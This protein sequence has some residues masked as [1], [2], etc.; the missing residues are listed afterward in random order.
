MVS[1]LVGVCESSAECRNF[2]GAGIIPPPKSF[3]CWYKTLQ[4]PKPSQVRNQ[5]NMR[6]LFAPNIDAALAAHAAKLHKQYDEWVTFDLTVVAYCEHHY[7]S[8]ADLNTFVT[9][10]ESRDIFYALLPAFTDLL[11]FLDKY[12]STA[13]N[14]FGDLPQLNWYFSSFR[15]NGLLEY[16][17]LT[18][19]DTSLRRYLTARRVEQL[20]LIGNFDPGPCILTGNQ[21]IELTQTIAAEATATFA[22]HKYEETLTRFG[23]ISIAISVRRIL[24]TWYRK[25]RHSLDLTLNY[26]TN[27]RRKKGSGTLIFEPVYEARFLPLAH[28]KVYF[29]PN[30]PT[31]MPWGLPKQKPDR[32]RRPANLPITPTLPLPFSKLK[33]AQLYAKAMTD[34]FCS[35]ISNFDAALYG[36]LWVIKNHHIN[37]ALIPMP[38][39][40]A[41]P[42]TLVVELLRKLGIQVFGLQHGG[43]YGDQNLDLAHLLS[44]YLYY[45]TFLA[46][47]ANS[48]NWSH[49]PNIGLSPCKIVPVGSLKAFAS[50][51]EPTAQNRGLNTQILFPITGASD[52]SSGIPLGKGEWVFR[53]QEAILARL[54]A[55]SCLVVV[56]PL[57]RYSHRTDLIRNYPI[58]FTLAKL[59]H[60]RTD[61]RIS[62]EAAL[63]RYRPG[64]VIFE[65]FSTPLYETLA[66]DC[67]IIQLID[68]V[69]PPEVS[70]RLMLEKRVHF[71]D[72]VEQ[73]LGLIDAFAGGKLPVLRNNEYYYQCVCP[74]GDAIQRV[75]G[76]LGWIK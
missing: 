25:G 13:L 70:V 45:D 65:W 76:H 55:L 42:K 4:H 47:K 24:L 35:T 73:L 14:C 8:C 30:H 23:A 28:Q 71:A 33:H 43:C 46:Y 2:A 60:C 34:F 1:Y 56:K 64:L 48:P 18:L 27:L 58:Q 31:G 52:I 41:E 12:N 51:S 54:D 44:D 10:A 39:C 38:A 37:K 15:L 20:N 19:F 75:C 40:A 74:P 59:R 50:Q 53:A 36:A 62:Y 26:A 72:S 49:V 5:T 68:P 22:R 6:A 3:E 16:A 61:A 69:C 66:F 9:A 29:W 67:D 7:I 11:I 17:G 63:Q 57:R 21:Y 32:L